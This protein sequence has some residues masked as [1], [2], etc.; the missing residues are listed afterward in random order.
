MRRRLRRLRR[1]F[2]IFA[3]N[4]LLLAVY[5]NFI[6]KDKPEFAPGQ[7]QGVIMPASKTITDN[8]TAD[9][10]LHLAK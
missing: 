4:L 6:H 2:M 10:T 3:L 5:L 1:I 8:A 9:K 7:T